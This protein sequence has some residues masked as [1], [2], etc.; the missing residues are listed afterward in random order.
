M[1]LNDVLFD[2]VFDIAF[3][4]HQPQK[5][6]SMAQSITLG[7]GYSITVSHDDCG[8]QITLD[9][10]HFEGVTKTFDERGN[11]SVEY[12]GS[13]HTVARLTVGA[14]RP[15]GQE[16]TI[17]STCTIEL[18]DIEEHEL[19]SWLFNRLSRHARHFHIEDQPLSTDLIEEIARIARE[20]TDETIEAITQRRAEP[21]IPEHLADFLNSISDLGMRPRIANIGG[22]TVIGFG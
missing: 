7:A 13:P 19:D 8:C 3:I 22:L 21:E 2:S 16:R 15:E 4:G 9:I 11:M 6:V 5:G 20:M 12:Q 1:H 17:L 14:G 18:V 10:A